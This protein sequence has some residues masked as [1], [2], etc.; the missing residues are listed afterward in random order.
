LA[1]GVWLLPQAAIRAIRKISKIAV[2]L[3]LII[4]RRYILLLTASTSLNKM[5]AYA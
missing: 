1:V 2:N 4:Y 3:F 5:Q